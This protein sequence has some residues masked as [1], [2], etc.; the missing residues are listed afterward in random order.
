M[1]EQYTI[2]VYDTRLVSKVEELYKNCRD[3]YTSKNPFMV[4][5]LV[6]G[7]EVI[8]R[9]LF[10]TSETDNVDELYNEVK[11]TVKKLDNLLK[12]CEKSAKESIANIQINQRLLSSNYNMLLGL[13]E[14]KPKRKEEVDG[15]WC[16]NLPTRLEEVMEELIQHFSSK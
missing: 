3:I 6:R 1:N 9:E 11:L 4:D 14:N 5:C 16:D 15:G 12:L 10:G 13:S 7:M 2:R 8:E